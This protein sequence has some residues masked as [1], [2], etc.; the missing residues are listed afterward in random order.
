MKPILCNYYLT[1]RCNSRCQFCEIWQKPTFQLKNHADLKHVLENLKALKQI[2]VRF[3]D[4]T[5]GEP[6]LYPH[7]ATVLRF[8]RE[9]G[10]RTSI[11]TNCLLYEKVAR[12]ISGLVTY[13]HF[14]LDSLSETLHNEIRGV[15]A[16]A[17]VMQSI[18]IARQIGEQPDILFTV[19]K[20]NY[21][22]L[23]RLHLF[24]AEKQLIL[25]VNPVFGYGQQQNLDISILNYLDQFQKLPYVYINRALHK[26]R[27]DG[28]NQIGQP[29]CYAMSSTIVISPDNRILLPCFH[30]QTAANQIDGNLPAVLKSEKYQRFQAKEGRFKFCQGCAIS[31]YLDPS[32]TFR[33]DEYFRLSLISKAKYIFDKHCRTWIRRKE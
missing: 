12:E 4:F 1:F 16:F 23:P 32:F 26:F 10:L 28:G 33:V 3:V 30:Y 24:C 22:E 21:L 15:A 19:T 25:I 11:T 5:G 14:S 2:G 9:L 17:K 29:R 7:L 27:R 8:A 18:E 31:C 13:L 20:A 6:L